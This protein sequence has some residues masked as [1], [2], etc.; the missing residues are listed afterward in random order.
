MFGF[1]KG[2]LERPFGY[3]A[4]QRFWFD[5]LVGFCSEAEAPI[6]ILTDTKAEIHHASANGKDLGEGDKRV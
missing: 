5:W 3:G 4:V 2:E 1:G 6:E